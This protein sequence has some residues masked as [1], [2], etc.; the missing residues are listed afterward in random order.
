MFAAYISTSVDY[1]KW[2]KHVTRFTFMQNIKHKCKIVIIEEVIEIHYHVHQTPWTKISNCI[3][4]EREM[5][6]TRMFINS[7]MEYK[8]WNIKK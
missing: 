6:I 2:E 5:E 3:S 8:S 7:R 4:V 1:I